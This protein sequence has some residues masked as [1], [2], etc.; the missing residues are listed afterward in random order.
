MSATLAVYDPP[1]CCSTGVCGPEP[2][3]R[4]ARFAADL[5]WLKTKGVAV[6]RINLSQEPARFV[7]QPAVKALLDETGGDDLPAIV[8]GGDIVARGR[9]PDRAELAHLAGVAASDEALDYLA[10]ESVRALIAIGAASAAGCEPCFKFHY[11]AGRHLGLRPEQMRMAADIGA[12]VRDAAGQG[13]ARLTERLL[14]APAKASSGCCGG[15][16]TPAGSKA[17]CC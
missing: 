11:D 15:G 4:L 17:G 16:T 10:S 12:K 8:I 5:E 3:P 13:V 6:D 14:G 9:Y 7:E 1:M 2:D